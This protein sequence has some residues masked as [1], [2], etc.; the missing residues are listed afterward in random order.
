MRTNNGCQ[1]SRIVKVEVRDRYG[2]LKAV[3]EKS[4]PTMSLY[5]RVLVRDEKGEVKHD[6]GLQPA[7]SFTVNFLKFLEAHW[8]MRYDPTDTGDYTWK[9]DVP[10]QDVTNTTRTITTPSAYRDVSRYAH[11]LATAGD[12][13]ANYGIVLGTG[14]GEESNTDYVLGSKIASGSGSGQLDYGPQSFVEPYVNGS[15]ID[16]VLSRSFYN[17]SGSPVTAT[18]FGLYIKN[19]NYYFCWIRDLEAGGKTVLA[20]D[21]MVV[22]YTIRCGAGWVL[23]F[24]YGLKSFMQNILYTDKHNVTGVDSNYVEDSS[25]ATMVGVP[26]GYWGANNWNNDMTRGLVVGSGTDAEAFTD[27]GL[28]T[29]IP[30]TS[31]TH[32]NENW[33]T[34]AV[35]GANVDLIMSRSF[36]NPGASPVTVRELAFYAG[37]GS[38]HTTGLGSAFCLIR[39]QLGVGVTIDP[40]DTGTVQYTWRTNVTD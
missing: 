7:H 27:V 28:Q 3:A 17:A 13:D 30:N 10:A 25:D 31:L 16:F 39:D 8:R 14:V 23:N 32:L 18:E 29:Q 11:M 35:V 4:Q 15:S 34:A 33:T 6:S 19:G 9:P 37:S 38:N 26:C 5:K 40:G 1:V 22:Q 24:L 12:G 2:N 20:G 36:Y 21:T